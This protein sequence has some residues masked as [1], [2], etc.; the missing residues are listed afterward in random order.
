MKRDI[1]TVDDIS[2]SEMQG[3]FALADEFLLSMHAPG[4][5]YLLRGRGSLA[6]K[7]LIATLFYEPS[8][9][10]RFSFETAMIRLGGHVISSADPYTTSASKG[11]TLA[12]TVRVLEN[13]A[14]LI[15]LRHPC[16]GAAQ[17]AAEFTQVP[18]IN[19][20][21]GSHEHPTQTLCDLY[22]LGKEKTNLN[23][24]SVLICGDLK[25]GRTT[26]SLV[27]ALVRFGAHIGLASAPGLELPA[28]VQSRLEKDY[29]CV[30]LKDS[31][32]EDLFGD[33]PVEVVYV[34]PNKPNQLALMP[35]GGDEEWIKRVLAKMDSRVDVC[36]VTRLQLERL[37]SNGRKRE[38]A[39]PVIDRQFLHGKR[40]KE[41]KVLHPLPRVDELAYDIDKDPRAAY[42]KQVAYGVPVRMALV[43]SVLGLRPVLVQKPPEKNYP[44]YSRRGSLVCSNPK[45]ITNHDPDKKVVSPK[46][47]IIASAP[48]VLRCCYCENEQEIH[49]AAKASQRTYFVDFADKSLLSSI[50]P[51]DL[52]IFQSEQE[53][54]QHGYHPR[55]KNVGVS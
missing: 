44:T 19:A 27:Y 10:T 8:T 20:G 26:H 7:H 48:P 4:S 23:G 16:E 43:A 46:F 9:R 51:K 24:L 45:C 31:A 28:H 55:H 14:D 13:Y 36:Y 1:I 50:E 42:F 2:N 29:G 11:E 21:D 32:I 35:F 22:T 38:G 37:P 41:T 49:C 34:T 25:Y 18:V 54:R 52:I 47:F 17:L 40:Y 3:L 6:N 15:V 12:D 5:D 30:P 39:Y 33:A 53:A